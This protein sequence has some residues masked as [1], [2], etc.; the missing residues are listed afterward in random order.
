MFAFV[1][2]T[3]PALYCNFTQ[4]LL[5][6]V[7]NVCLSRK[8]LLY[9]YRDLQHKRF[10]RTTCKAHMIAS[11]FYI[12][13]QKVP[14]VCI[15]DLNPCNIYLL[16]N[17]MQYCYYCNFRQ[18]FNEYQIVSTLCIKWWISCKLFLFSHIMQ[19]RCK[20]TLFLVPI[21]RSITFR[22]MNIQCTFQKTMPES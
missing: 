13:H 7:N 8:V 10:E 20:R 3:Y 21:P 2:L 17:I 22:K 16:S 12:K 18:N 4:V 9:L 14:T 15:K 11:I 5:C 19:Y 6:L 1:E